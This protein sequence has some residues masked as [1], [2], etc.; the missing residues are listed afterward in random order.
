MAD[1]AIVKQPSVF[2]LNSTDE[3]STWY[4]QFTNYCTA[5]KIEAKD[6][7]L[8]LSSFLDTP[9]FAV[10]QNLGISDA[11]QADPTLYSA[12]LEEALTPKEKIPPRLALRYRAQEPDESLADFA[13]ALEKLATKAGVPAASRPELLVDSFCTGVR[14]TDLSIKL[15]ET[16]FTNL[17]L[18]LD[19]AQ[20]IESAS[21]IRKFVR[22]S[23]NNPAES[24]NLEIL[25]AEPA[26]SKQPTPPHDR[27]PNQAGRFN[28]RDSFHHN[29]PVFQPGR[30]E[31]A[32]SRYGNFRANENSRINFDRPDNSGNRNSNNAGPSYRNTKRCWYCNRLGHLSKN[33]RTKARDQAQNFP[34][35][36]SPRQ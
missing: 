10:V 19:Q 6:R 21:K 25:A 33:C 23:N 4:A 27:R 15:L 36:P 31:H 1:K 35:G 26:F 9:A 17:T 34:M 2:K 32:T 28:E 30:P 3:Y 8:V 22:P 14:D 7:F 5:V 13:F 11:D 12:R 20:K 18:A 16:S 24:A 29:V